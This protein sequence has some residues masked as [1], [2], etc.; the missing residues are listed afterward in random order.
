MNKKE[1]MKGMKA[2]I[3]TGVSLLFILI[4]IGGFVSTQ[5]A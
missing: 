4:V 3:L 1:G 5:G 2:I